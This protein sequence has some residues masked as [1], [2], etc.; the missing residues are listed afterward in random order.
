MFKGDLKTALDTTLQI[1]YTPITFFLIKKKNSVGHSGDI[2]GPFPCFYI[3]VL[4]NYH[5]LS[6][7]TQSYYPR[8]GGQKAG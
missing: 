8:R 4:K 5:K 6:G 7:L 3:D 1:S 2:C